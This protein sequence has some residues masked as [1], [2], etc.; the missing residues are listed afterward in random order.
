MTNGPL[1]RTAETA[2]ATYLSAPHAPGTRGARGLD[3]A[4]HTAAVAAYESTCMLLHRRST[5]AGHAEAPYRRGNGA[6][7]LS[8]ARAMVQATRRR[9][10]VPCMLPTQTLAQ[11]HSGAA[12]Q[13]GCCIV[14]ALARSQELPTPPDSFPIPSTTR[15]RPWLNPEYTLC[16]EKTL[17]RTDCG[18][19]TFNTPRHSTT[20]GRTK[21]RHKRAHAYPSVGG[22]KLRCDR[23]GGCSGQ[24]TRHARSG[25]LQKLY[26]H[27]LKS[28]GMLCQAPPAMSKNA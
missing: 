26:T 16:R 18:L 2:T 5:P 6:W 8:M 24:R 25:H 27:D 17:C 20:L 9:C 21:G 1:S 13:P 12:I 11:A 7:L 4:N 28:S 14:R 3:D 15:P 10:A 19:V 23:L 22:C